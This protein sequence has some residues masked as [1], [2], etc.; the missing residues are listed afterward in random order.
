MKMSQTRAWGCPF[1]CVHTRPLS[2]VLPETPPEFVTP[3]VLEA[4]TGQHI[5]CALGGLFPASE[6]QAHLAL[7]DRRLNATVT[8]G[9][10][11]LSATALL[12]ATTQEEGDQRLVC[13]V[14]LG[15]RSL[16]SWRNL[17]VYSKGRG[18]VG[19]ALWAWAL[20]GR[21][22]TT[23][24]PRLASAARTYLNAIKG[25]WAGPWWAG[26]TVCPTPRLSGAHPDLQLD[27]G[28]RGGPG[29]GEL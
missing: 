3:G 4:G 5:T 15:N 2:P 29:G 13:A 6:A 25:A 12:Q 26:L 21:A 7:G 17:T 14:L 18:A 28:L 27:R 19:V 10:D 20:L 8:R 16:E 9:D 22:H 24:R 1:L 23:P 11:S